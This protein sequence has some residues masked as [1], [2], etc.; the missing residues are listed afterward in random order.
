MNSKEG[1]EALKMLIRAMSGENDVIEHMEKE[2]QEKVVKNI[3]MAREM[4]PNKEE[5]E[6]LGFIFT[7]IP[8]DNVL[9]NVVLPEGWSLKATDHSMWNDII[10]E[11][12]MVRGSMFYKSSFYDREAHMTLNR[13]YGVCS[14][15]VNGDYSTREIFFG[16]ENEK[17]FV[18]GQTHISKDMSRED[19][20][21]IYERQKQL[22]KMAQE[23]GD[24]NYP[25]WESVHAYWEK[26]PILSLKKISKK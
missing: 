5:W 10:D 24:E 16:N 21:M 22:E 20:L 23:F 17:L 26:E 8:G 14:C 9:C 6:Q 3:M 2:S 13:R 19:R 15:C 18:A 11:N 7:D 25:G 4:S 12:G 1:I